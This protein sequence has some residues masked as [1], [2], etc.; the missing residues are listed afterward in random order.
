VIEARA[1]E[2]RLARPW[3]IARGTTTEKRVVVV[4]IAHGAEV[5][6]GEASPV[7]RFGESV[8][9]A[10]AAVQEIAKAT[11]DPRA[12]REAARRIAGAVPGELAA[13]AAVD[14]AVHD[15]AGKL[16]GAPLHRLLGIDPSR[17]PPTSF[18]LGIDEPAI[19]AEK[20]REASP[21]GVLK[22]K[23]GSADDR[24]LFGAVRAA[25]DKPI[26]VDA[27]EAW[28]DPEAALAFIHELAAQGVE[29]VEQ[30][31]PA[32]DLEGARWLAARSPIPVVADE[33]LTTAA[34]VPRL[35][36][37][38]HG[39]NVKLQKC[40]GIQE[41]L[42]VLEALRAHGMKAM[43][44]CML[45]TSLGIAAAAQIAPLFDWVD[46]DGNLLLADDPFVGH[47]VV[48]GRIALSDAPGLG[49]SPRA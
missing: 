22:V 41:A 34:D 29:L 30:P 5:G 35:A 26:R 16:L 6:L 31:L 37:A 15:L 14:A 44:G 24:A 28:R 20:V 13:K 2:V 42:R 25:T 45:E 49:V 43:L 12:Y 47:P 46:L 8:E 11:L 19:I 4:S 18:T 9:S 36:G 1:V 33:A 17:M 3:T 10:L 21:Y 7:S 23:L 40:G 48:D 39:A 27:N 38:Y 32:A